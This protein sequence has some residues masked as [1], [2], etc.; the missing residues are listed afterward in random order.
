MLSVGVETHTGNSFELLLET[1]WEAV[2][3]GTFQLW[4]RQVIYC[5]ELVWGSCCT[6]AVCAALRRPWLSSFL[7]GPLIRVTALSVAQVPGLCAILCAQ[8]HFQV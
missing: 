4:E 7:W 6:S 1:I 3:C 5:P 2:S 8:T